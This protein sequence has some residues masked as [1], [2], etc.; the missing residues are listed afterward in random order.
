MSC[1][2]RNSSVAYVASLSRYSCHF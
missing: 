1:H 2:V